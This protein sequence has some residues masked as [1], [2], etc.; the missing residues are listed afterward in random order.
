M[1]Q[2]LNQRKLLISNSD[3]RPEPSD[4]TEIAADITFKL[5]ISLKT[6]DKMVNH[7]NQIPD[8][9]TEVFTV[10]F[11]YAYDPVRCSSCCFGDVGS[12]SIIFFWRI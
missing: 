4:D 10:C 5:D 3:V 1:G 2:K 9:V 6:S 7:L 12:G 11:H 8:A